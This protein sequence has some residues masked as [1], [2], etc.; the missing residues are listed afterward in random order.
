MKKVL[1]G[2][3]FGS[4]GAYVLRDRIL[5]LLGKGERQG[6]L[7]N[8]GDPGGWTPAGGPDDELVTERVKSEIF[9]GTDVSSRQVNVNTEYGRVILRGELPS[10]DLVQELVERARA[11]EGV[12]DVESQISVAA[13]AGDTPAQP[14]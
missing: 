10:Q 11:V 7:G 3:A 2:I 12:A 1:L 13:G 6:E 4:A 8:F 9:R 5:E 14:S